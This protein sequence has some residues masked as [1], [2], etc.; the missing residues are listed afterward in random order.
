MDTPNSSDPDDSLKALIDSG[1]KALMT[2]ALR[3]TEAE[4]QRLMQTAG[5]LR[6]ALSDERENA[7][8]AALGGLSVPKY[9]SGE[10]PPWL[11]N[12]LAGLGK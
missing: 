7:P 4:I 6:L 5:A 8:E 11:K 9:A 1:N 10:P 3:L 12:M 2:E